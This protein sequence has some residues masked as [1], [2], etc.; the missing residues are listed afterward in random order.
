M[1]L[2]PATF[3]RPPLLEKVTRH[4]LVKWPSGQVIADTKN[5]YWVLETHHPPTYYIPRSDVKLP[6]TKTS[7]STYCE[8]KGAASYFSIASPDDPGKKVENRIWFYENPTPRFKEIKDYVSFY[9]GP[10]ECYV[11]G[12]KGQSVVRY[13]NNTHPSC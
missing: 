12:E 2:N 11:D 7:R 4:L 3:P 13:L 8:W 9:N 6:L 1:P 5:A 10:W